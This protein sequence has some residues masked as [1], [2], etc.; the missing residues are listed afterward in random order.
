[1]EI[2]TSEW[3]E[4]IAHW[5]RTLAKDLYAPLGEI[6][7]ESFFTMEHMPLDK[8]KV[9]KFQTMKAGMPWGYTW[10]YG[11]FRGTIRMPKEASGK[12]I[13]MNLAQ[14][15]EATLFVNDKAFGTYRA[16]WIEVPHHYLVDN[17]LTE[18]AEEGDV[19]EIYMEVYA[20]HHFPSQE[21][22][23]ARRATGPILEGDYEDPLIQGKRRHL[24]RSTFGIWNEEAYQL[25]MDVKILRSLLEVLDEGSL[26]AVKVAEA[27]EQFT[28]AVD[29]EQKP[30]K[31]QEDYRKAREVVRPALEAENGSTVP[32]FYAVGNAHIDLA[33]LW[34]FAETHRKTARTFAAQLRLL[35]EYPEYL[36]MQSQPAIYEMCREHYPELFDRIVLAQK[37][38]RWIADGAMWV[39]PDTNL[40]SGEALIRQLIYGKKYFK[41]VFGVD[42]QVLWLPDT[43]GYTGALPQILKGCGVRYLVTQKIFW[44]YNG[45]EPFPYHYFS[46]EGIDGSKVT[47][48]LPTSYT[49]KANPQEVVE[50]WEKRGQKRELEAF[51]YPVGYGDG[52]GGPCRDHIESI[53]RMGNLEGC[54][55]VKMTAPLAFFRQM[56]A[57]GGPAHTYTGELYLSAHR[58]T[59]TSQAQMKKNNRRAE[60][61]LRKLE[62]W[63]AL[64]AQKN[65]RYPA[66]ELEALWKVVLLHQFHDILPG[67]SIGRVYEEAEDTFSQLFAQGAL[68]EQR[69]IDTLSKKDGYSVWNPLGFSRKVVVA[70]PEE[71]SKGV[72]VNGVAQPVEQGLN[73]PEALI[74]LA[75]M[76][77]VSLTPIADGG[78]QAIDSKLEKACVEKIGDVYLMENRLVRAQI[79]GQGRVISFCLKRNGKIKEFVAEPMNRFCMYKDVP[80]RYD[81]WD[82][83]S[84]YRMQELEHSVSGISVRILQAGNLRAALEVT[85]TI[86]N[87]PYVQVI[88]LDAESSRLEF[89]TKIDWKE[90]HRLLKV[91]FPVHVYAENGINEIQFGYVQRPTHRSRPYDQARFEVCNH[92]YTALCDQN[93][94][95]AILNDC[96]YGISMN[97][98]AM[99]L[100]LLRAATVPERY[101]DRKEHTFV[102]AFTAWEGSFYSSDVVKQGYELNTAVSVRKRGCTGFSAFC[103]EQENVILETVKMAE[104]GSKDMIFRLYESKKAR[105]EAIFHINQECLGGQIDSASLCDMLEQEKEMLEMRGNA[106]LLSFEPFEILTIRLKMKK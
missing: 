24:G 60:G 91:A 17:T 40:A 48:F 51:L 70:L 26:R 78:A 23:N 77:A 39:E 95:A 25:Y 76:G 21:I 101:T 20:G 16:D 66:E 87:S 86:G 96:K 84:N 82:M 81:A 43:F 38:G 50:V 68:L 36:F 46:W 53:R 98:N 31:R 49:Y 45:G 15:G 65:G 83:D 75:S 30:E 64:A 34:P 11:W 106:L 12:R 92:R 8:V 72:C 44:S 58:G 41:E 35:D 69:A 14:D 105:T 22:P 93:Q 90:Q 56:D 94:G 5:I 99:E 104:D 57:E 54:V 47:A 85:G 3:E 100:T 33:W 37:E 73:G 19:Y 7:W 97:G 74:E 42:S 9:Q 61:M 10:E 52:G 71:F 89:D 55:K 4:R 62:L 28:L 102:Y 18:S 88:R 79:D 59:Y 63:S 6:C 13:V 32:R 67:T 103:V 1:M 80:R 27:L 29:F 2:L